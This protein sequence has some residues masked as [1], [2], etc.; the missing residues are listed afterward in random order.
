VLY[1]T[2]DGYEIKM[3]KAVIV[4]AARTPQ[5]RFFG[6]L[7]DKSAVDLACAAG[8]AAMAR[9]DLNHVDMVI[10][11]NVISAAQGM[12]IGRQV[13]VKL[14]IPLSSPGFTINMMCAS[15]MKAVMLAV[16]AVRSGEAEVVL[17]G[18]SESMSN[19]PYALP[20]RYTGQKPGD[21][22]LLDTIFKDGLVDSFNQ[23]HMG[24]TAEILADQYRISRQQQDTFALR[25]Q[26]RYAAAAAAEVFADEIVM[27][28]GLLNDEHP[29]PKVTSAEL[30]KL[31]S[32]FSENGTVTAGNSS[33][34]NDGAAML[35]VASDSAAERYG[36]KPLATV[37]HYASVGCEPTRMGLGPVYAVRKLCKAT[38]IDQSNYE[39]IELNEA[40]AAQA[41]ACI[42]ELKLD[43]V[44]VNMCGGAIALGHP[45]GASGARLIVHLSHRISKGDCSNGLA[46]LCVGGG[47]GVAMALTKV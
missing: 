10:V 46:A 12:N 32:T 11:G 24:K 43:P 18:G 31:K 47:M 6:A 22:K 14:G 16:D 34:I 23:M 4:A 35:V 42:A 41:I 25:S 45:I 26:H 36:W 28:D 44:K 9:I 19:A 39:R 1:N 13:G 7:A 8:V 29:R 2:A 33:G 30:Q 21:L 17:C 3:N 37:Q 15:G 20:R 27:V 38:G 40:F 5:G